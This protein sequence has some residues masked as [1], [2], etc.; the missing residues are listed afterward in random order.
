MLVF[1]ARGRACQLSLRQLLLLVR[2]F[3]AGKGGI[4]LCP[5]VLILFA[6]GVAGQ[7]FVVPC[8]LLLCGLEAQGLLEA[9]LLRQIRL[10]RF[11]RQA[12][13]FVSNP[14]FCAGGGES[15]HLWLHPDLLAELFL[16]L[17]FVVVAQGLL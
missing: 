9:L 7:R 15:V 8:S 12:L 3:V 16:F 10:E 1:A 11:P 6:D 2:H 13:L 5:A 17:L 4:R 14:G